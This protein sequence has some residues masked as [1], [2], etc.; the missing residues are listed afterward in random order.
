MT[1]LRTR[2]IVGDELL[3]A[4]DAGDTVGG[5]SAT[6][7]SAAVYHDA[8]DDVVLT[9]TPGDSLAAATATR[10]SGARYHGAA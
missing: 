6:R 4:Y 10:A 5:L 1:T 2:V 3:L 7:A 9:Y 8:L